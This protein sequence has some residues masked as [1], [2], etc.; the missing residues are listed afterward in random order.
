MK[1]LNSRVLPA[2]LAVALLLPASPA[3]LAAD[4][5]KEA[6]KA[7]DLQVQV[8]VPAS[9]QPF[10]MDDIAEALGRVLADSF[11]R[12]GYAG[13]IQQ[14]GLPETAKPD[15]PLLTVRLHEWRIS[16]TGNAECTLTATLRAGGKE[17]DLGIVSYT[18]L[19]WIQSRGRFGVARDYAVAE[20]Y[21]DAAGGAMRELFKRVAATG[22]V[23]NLAEKSRK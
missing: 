9:W 5:A 18:D 16:R 23:P 11:K 4:R 19:S 14:V 21:E 7:P 20:A 13:N 12:R 6:A 10:L 1:L 15:L 3:L 22:A 2:A 8:D 17:H